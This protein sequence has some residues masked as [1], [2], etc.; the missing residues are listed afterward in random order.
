MSDVQIT[1][2]EDQ[3]V[4]WAEALD[5]PVEAQDL[6]DSYLGRAGLLA[7]AIMMGLTEPDVEI[8]P[9]VMLALGDEF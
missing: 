7:N 1:S 2:V 3:D 4:A 8:N 9:D 6:I 5:V